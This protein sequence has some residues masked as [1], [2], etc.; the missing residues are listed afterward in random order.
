MHVLIYYTLSKLLLNRGKVRETQMLR[1]LLLIIFL[2][3]TTFFSYEQQQL[4]LRYYPQS[5]GLWHP[6]YGP[7]KCRGLIQEGLFSLGW[8]RLT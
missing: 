1:V 2:D 5:N 7:L 4:Y 3:L 6:M 8:F